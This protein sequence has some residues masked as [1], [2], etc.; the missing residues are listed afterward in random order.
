MRR[1]VLALALS[2]LAASPV[3]A[4]RAGSWE[5]GGFARYNWYDGSFN[6]PDAS[7]E[8]NSFGGGIRLGWFFTQ[9]WA[10]ELDGSFN[11]TDIDGLPGGA[12]SVGLKYWPFHLRVIYNAPLSESFSW[13]LGAGANYNRYELS[14]DAD[15]FLTNRFE[16]SDFGVGGLTG[17]RYRF[18]ELVSLRIDGTLDYIPSPENESV[19]SNVMWGLQAGLSLHFGGQGNAL[20]SIMVEPRNS[21]VLVGQQ[22]T[23]RVTGYYADGTTRDVTASTTAVLAGGQATVAGMT[24]SSNTPGTYQVRFDNAAARRRR[25]DVAVITVTPQPAPPADTLVR[26]DLQPD[27]ATV[28]SNES[29][30]LRVTGHYSVSQPR[31]LT[32]CT[33]TPDGGTVTGGAFTATRPGRYTITAVCERGKSDRAVV[34]VRSI[35]ITLRALFRF[36][37]TNVYVQEELDSLR[38]VAQQMSEHPTLQLTIYGHADQIGSDAYNCNLGWRRIQAVVDTLRSF[39]VP[40]DR[41]RAAA[42]TSYGERQPVADNDTAE[43]RAQN[44]RVEVFDAGSA[45]A[46]DTSKACG[47]R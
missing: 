33:L 36:N 4:Q 5:V 22:V 47:P 31:E 46:Y 43:G 32:D 15:A 1:S 24:F 42:K 29:L 11:A 21:T 2:V 12:Q 37:R 44:R 6:V 14:S 8:K 30:P 28:F 38:V 13:L 23:F 16:G 27:S 45:R 9:N 34:N 35:N 17:F 7:K 25:T 10:L 39:G 40:D 20:D 19:N 41:L 3:M 18:S 26:V